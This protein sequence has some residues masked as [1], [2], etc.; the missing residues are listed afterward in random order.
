MRR[1]KNFF[2][3]V[4]KPNGDLL[5]VK[6][7]NEPIGGITVKINIRDYGK[8]LEIPKVSTDT[9]LTTKSLNDDV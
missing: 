1:S 4:V 8:G 7:P 5:W 6:S 3:L 9:K 2:K